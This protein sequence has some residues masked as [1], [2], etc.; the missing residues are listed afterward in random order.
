[1]KVVKVIDPPSFPVPA[2]NQKRMRIP[3]PRPRPRPR[4]RARRARPRSSTST[5]RSRARRTCGSSPACPSS[6]QCRGCTRGR[7]MFSCGRRTARRRQAG[8][9][10]PVHR[11]LPAASRRAPAARPRDA[12]APDPD[13]QRAAR[14]GQVHGGR[15]PRPGLRRGRQARD[16]R[17]RRLPPPDPAPDPQDAQRARASPT[18]S[19]APATCSEAMTPG[20]R[21]RVAGAARRLV[22]RARRAPASARRG[23]R[24]VLDRMADGG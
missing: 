15:Q 8:G 18:S 12:A 21:G 3:R 10:L 11:G 20:G 1:M 9:V 5:G 16:H 19:P 6:P 2:A 7:S 4:H 17:R 22:D 23:C 24:E 14:R 13:R